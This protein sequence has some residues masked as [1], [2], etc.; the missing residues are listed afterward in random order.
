MAADEV[1]AQ[2]VRR[3]EQ[4]DIDIN[5]MHIAHGRHTSLKCPSIPSVIY[6]APYAL[7]TP[8]ALL[9]PFPPQE[10]EFDHAWLSH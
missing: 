5:I 6:N 7:P 4:K 9:N 8:A 3:L 1:N 10:V 2:V